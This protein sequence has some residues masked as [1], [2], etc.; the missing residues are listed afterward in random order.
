MLTAPFSGRGGGDGGVRDY[1]AQGMGDLVALAHARRRR[2]RTPAGAA[3]ST[4]ARARAD[5]TAS[6]RR[7]QSE[8]EPEPEPEPKS[9]PTAR[10]TPELASFGAGSSSAPCCLAEEYS[11]PTCFQRDVQVIASYMQ[12]S[13]TGRAGHC[14]SHVDLADVEGSASARLTDLTSVP[15]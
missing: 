11:I 14:K 6:L 3:G 7:P 15:I 1:S 10:V 9:V 13:C 8:P 2:A 5:R 12:V 4:A